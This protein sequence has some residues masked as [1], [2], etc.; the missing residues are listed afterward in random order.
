MLLRSLVVVAEG[1]LAL[2]EALEEAAAVEDPLS[3]WEAAALQVKGLE[4]AL[5]H[6]KLAAVVAV[7]RNSEATQHLT[8]V[9]TAEMELYLQSQDK[10]LF[11]EVV[12]AVLDLIWEELAV[13]AA[14]VMAA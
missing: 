14:V 4:E 3:P 9:E 6:H 10:A 5:V 12:V 8:M 7:R 2:Q 13:M 1:E 11:T